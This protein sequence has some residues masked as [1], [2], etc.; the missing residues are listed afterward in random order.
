[1]TKRNLWILIIVILVVLLVVSCVAFTT[2]GV[3]LYN[4]YYVDQS[5]VL[6]P[7]VEPV[8]PACDPSTVPFTDMGELNPDVETVIV[9]P[10]IY[11]WWTGGSN[12][13]VQ[14]VDTGQSVTIHGAQGHYWTLPNQ[15]SLDCAWMLH[16][17]NYGAKPQHAG[18]TYN[19]LVVPPPA[20]LLK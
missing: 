17:G 14:R 4:R 13:G 2:S 20:D 9:G 6:C 3:L 10:A 11:E 5:S 8:T 12:E 19:D 16:V 18:K 1:M 15:Q 7:L